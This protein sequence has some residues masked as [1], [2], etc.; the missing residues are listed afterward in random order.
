VLKALNVTS[1]RHVVASPASPAAAAAET[2]PDLV[3]P[4][5]VQPDCAAPSVISPQPVGERPANRHVSAMDT[6]PCPDGDEHVGV[7]LQHSAR[8]DED[9]GAAMGAATK[10]LKLDG[11][12]AGVA[13]E[14]HRACQYGGSAADA[15]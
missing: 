9:D 14:S 1:G 6:A 8:G 2:A 11:G 7:A 5:V 13:L 15:P 10:R 3:S 12:I 4:P